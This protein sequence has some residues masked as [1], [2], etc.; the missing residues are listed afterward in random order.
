M[1]L[2]LGLA[3]LVISQSAW[4]IVNI[5]N[6]R[7]DE[8][9][10]GWAAS[11]TLGANGKRG[12]TDEDNFS[13]TGGVQ[14][15][16]DNLKRRDLLLY[17]AGQSQSQGDT[18]SESYFVHYRHTEQLTHSWA[19]ESFLQHESEPLSNDSKR[20]LIGM[21]ARYRLDSFPFNGFGGAGIMYEERSIELL[22]EKVEDT[23]TRFNFYL[24]SKYSLS[25][26]T[27]WKISLYAQPKTDDFDNLRTVVSTGLTTRINSVFAFTLDAAYTHDSEP[28]TE[29]K[30]YDFSYK[31]GINI[32]F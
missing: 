15:I 29:Q 27:D 22:G 16:S 11:T 32:R 28:L 18:Y 12:N 20:N 23:G 8:T 3:S 25:E 9:Q 24:D 7:M 17:D 10:S 14:Y 1:R 31:T 30:N 21:N 6:L 26:T 2:A 19:W 13:I 4:A 5:E